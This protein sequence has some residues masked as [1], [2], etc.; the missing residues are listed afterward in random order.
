MGIKRKDVRISI[1]RDYC[2]SCGICIEFC[3]QKVFTKG[4][5]GEPVVDS[6]EKCTVCRLCEI[7]CPDFAVIV[8]EGG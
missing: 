5:N 2:K 6:I 1:T 8:E 7:R 3:A 4:S